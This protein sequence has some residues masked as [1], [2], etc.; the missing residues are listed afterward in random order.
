MVLALGWAPLATLLT[1][2]AARYLI[3]ARRVRQGIDRR[4]WGEST[5]GR[6]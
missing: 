5:E 2:N 3:G 6:A 1:L 4:V